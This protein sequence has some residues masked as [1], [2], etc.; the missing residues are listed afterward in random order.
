MDA[1]EVS[2]VDGEEQLPL[3]N[4][5][6]EFMAG[7]SLDRRDSYDSRLEEGNDEYMLDGFV[8]DSDEEDSDWSEARSEITITQ[9]LQDE[10]YVSET[11]SDA[12]LILRRRSTRQDSAVSVD[13]RTTSG[14]ESSGLF[15]TDGREEAPEEFPFDDYFFRPIEDRIEPS[16]VAEEITNTVTRFARR[17]N[18]FTPPTCLELTRRFFEDEEVAEAV[19]LAI[20]RGFCTFKQMSDD[21]LLCVI[22]ALKV[23]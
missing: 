11:D 17:C 8:V 5:N 18:R 15:V 7:D 1:S 16:D 10:E 23:E 3:S 4:D 14:S 6:F 12:P 19:L 2:S 22:G 13:S 20:D 21:T 9:P